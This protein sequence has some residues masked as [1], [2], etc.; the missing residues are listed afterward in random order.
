MW[1]KCTLDER[2]SIF[3][4]NKHIFSSKRM[5]HKDHYRNSSIEKITLIVGLN[6]LDAKTN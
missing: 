3:I 1:A 6:G 5:L 4:R 2:P